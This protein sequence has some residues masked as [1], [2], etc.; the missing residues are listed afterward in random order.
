MPSQPSRGSSH[1][2][3]IALITSE[4]YAYFPS[5]VIF[6]KTHKQVHKTPA[7][8]AAAPTTSSSDDPSSTTTP[9]ATS[10][11]LALVLKEGQY[12]PNPNYAYTG[13]LRPVY[14]LSEKRAVP[15]HIPRPD[16]ADDREFEALGGI[17]ERVQVCAEEIRADLAHRRS[18]WC[19]SRGRE[20]FGGHR[21]EQGGSADATTGEVVRC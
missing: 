15:A 10:A 6:Q 17:G 12:I 2:S 3:T 5:L 1:L 7:K 9:S 11:P 8:A 19:C 13:T 14:P 16:H 20:C 21:R 18:C 4:L